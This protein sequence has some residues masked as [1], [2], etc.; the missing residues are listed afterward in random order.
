MAYH[1]WSKSDLE[2]LNTMWEKHSIEEIAVA[3][4][5]KKKSVIQMAHTI[6]QMYPHALISKRLGYEKEITEVFGTK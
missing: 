3:I 5:V 6:R 1:K 4:G 2:L